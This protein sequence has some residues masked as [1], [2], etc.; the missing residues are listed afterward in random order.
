MAGLPNLENIWSDES[1]LGLSNLQFLEV[2]SCKS[3]S[4]VINCK[5]LVKLHKLHTLVVQ[6]CVS[7]QEIFDLDGLSAYANIETLSGPNTIHLT[8]LLGLRHIW[9]KN[10]RGIMR[11]HNLKEV[12]VDGCNNLR[13]MFFPSMVQYLAQLRH[14][15]IRDCK[16]MEV[17]I[18]EEEWLGIET[19][20]ILVFPVLANLVLVRLKS[21]TCFSC[22]K[23]NRRS[24]LWLK[25]I[26]FRIIM[27]P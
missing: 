3:L 17:I 20:E 4:K 9:N 25:L 10:P 8:K 18:M 22:R 12:H 23:H 16:K 13:F 27:A 1:P 2:S 19:S 11:L 24:P 15:I 7:V 14:L 5:T 26:L 6:S 21:L